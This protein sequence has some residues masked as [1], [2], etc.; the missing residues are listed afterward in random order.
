MR[1]D[2]KPVRIVATE[3]TYDELVELARMCWR[4][5]R[6][7]STSQEVAALLRQMAREYQQEAAKLDGG[8][9]PPIGDPETDNKPIE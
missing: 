3:R 4:Q 9:L 1:A 8:I 6:I 7:T 2:L 5:A